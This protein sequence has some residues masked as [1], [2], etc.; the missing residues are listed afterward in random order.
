MK[1]TVFFLCLPLFLSGCSIFTSFSSDT[2][3]AFFH[4]KNNSKANVTNIVIS[5][6]DN[7][8]VKST[9]I[10]LP[11][12]KSGDLNLDLTKSQVDGCYIITYVY[13]GLSFKKQFGYYSN[14]YPLEKHH[15]ILINGDKIDYTP[16]KDY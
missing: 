3:K 1:K 9:K 5:V 10:N 15:K 14:G 13:N 7:Q 12:G 8:N 11:T 6:S 4:I 2:D 16:V